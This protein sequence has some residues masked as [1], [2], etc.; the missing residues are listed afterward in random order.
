MHPWNPNKIYRLTR[1]IEPGSSNR[2]VLVSAHCVSVTWAAEAGS[3]NVYLAVVTVCVCVCGRVCMYLQW[4]CPRPVRTVQSAWIVSAT[5]CCVRV[6]TSSR[7]VTAPSR[8]SVV[9]TAVQYVA[10]TSPRSFT[11]ITRELCLH[12][13]PLL[14]V[15]LPCCVLYVVL[16]HMCIS[17]YFCAA[18]WNVASLLRYS[19]PVSRNDNVLAH[20]MWRPGCWLLPADLIYLSLSV[21]TAI[22]QVN[23]G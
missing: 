10:R 15:F 8:W 5:A 13:A 20:V 11:S 21:L 6:I 23:L 2:S 3:R 17:V 16:S 22:F 4:V 14:I 1:G 12:S 7:A 19:C 18:K 9:A